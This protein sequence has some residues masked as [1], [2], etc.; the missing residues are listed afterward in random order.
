MSG[1]G[2]ACEALRAWL[3]RRGLALTAW[4]PMRRFE[5][6]TKD[7]VGTQ[8][9]VLRHILDTNAGTVFGR[10]HG[11][12]SVRGPADFARC[13]PSGDYEAHRPY[14]LRHLAGERNVLTA[15]PVIM[16][17][18]TSGTTG[19]PKYVPVTPEGDRRA[20]RLMRLWLY[21]CL[22]SHP[23][24]Y[25]RGSAA[26]VSPAVE[27][28]APDGTPCGNVS[29]RIQARIPGFLRGSYVVPYEAMCIPDYDDRYFALARFLYARPPSIV[30][31]PNA[32]T[33]IRIVQVA[34]ERAEELIRGIHDGTL[35]LPDPHVIP[36]HDALQARLAPDPARAQELERLRGE[37]GGLAPA[38]A[39][40]GRLELV[41]CWLGGSAGLQLPRLR[42]LFGR[43][44]ALRDL[45][46]LASEGRM[47]LP[48]EDGTASGILAVDQ[49][50]YEFIEVDAQGEPRGPAVGC[51][52]VEEGR[53]Y[54]ILLT[55]Y[56]GL[57][58]YDINDIVRVTGFHAGT[59]LVEFVRKG[60]DMANLQGEKLHFNQVKEA[61]ARTA[62]YLGLE[63]VDYRLVPGA[64]S[65]G[66]VFQ[67][68]TAQPL[69]RAAMA[70]LAGLL[71]RALGEQ[72]CEYRQKRSS[73]RLDA[74]SVHSMAPGWRERETRRM[75]PAG[76]SDV[77][78]KWRY[79]LPEPSAVSGEAPV[80]VHEPPFG[81]AVTTAATAPGAAAAA[82]TVARRA[83]RHS[84]S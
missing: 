13:V 46:Y 28:H 66:Y 53:E 43:D 19:E 60:R 29:G 80:A 15:E 35:G 57:Y 49:G 22:K 4:R 76:R 79:L 25:D 55:T 39:W 38:R 75:R 81:G 41:G 32:S 78:F 1:M 69:P 30:G 67:V 23:R 9:A 47:S 34:D 54:S 62:E 61:V 68:E 33:L 31:T 6:A 8:E 64:A 77:Q 74:V 3:M 82:G 17:A 51:G 5:E 37:T 7:P 65:R 12:A 44:V 63:L 40:H 50:Y 2:M 45:G 14:V 71:D 21:G 58:R 10:R 52:E 24:C 70:R 26:I 48:L 72:N 59:P 27:A 11:F 42:E 73:S 20:S 84:R 36:H 56:G 83:I 16:F 18:T